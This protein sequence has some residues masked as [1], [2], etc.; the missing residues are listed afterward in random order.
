MLRKL[1]KAQQIADCVH[2]SR[3]A[4]KRRV[5]WSEYPKTDVCL[6]TGGT[7]GLIMLYLLWR[8]IDTLF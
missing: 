8:E 1:K 6:V 3:R 2:F 5:P 7:L 4:A